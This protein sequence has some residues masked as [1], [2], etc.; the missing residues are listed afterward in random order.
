[1]YSPGAIN[2][3]NK[4]MLGAHIWELHIE[5]QHRISQQTDQFQ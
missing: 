4:K 3:A 5:R 2:A 1:M